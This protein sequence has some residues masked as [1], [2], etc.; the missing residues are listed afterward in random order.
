MEKLMARE[1]PWFFLSLTIEIGLL[2]EV[3]QKDSSF[4]NWMFDSFVFLHYGVFWIRHVSFENSIKNS[5]TVP[6]KI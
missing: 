6:R 1:G 2:S 3:P 5:Q 4:T